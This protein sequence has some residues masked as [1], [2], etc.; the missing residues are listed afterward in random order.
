MEGVEFQTPAYL[1]RGELELRTPEP[2]M[3]SGSVTLRTD[4]SKTSGEEG[5]ALDSWIVT[6]A[7][8]SRQSDSHLR[9]R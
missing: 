3:G 7:G 1:G 6:R 5:V 8:T 4:R 9:S 2:G